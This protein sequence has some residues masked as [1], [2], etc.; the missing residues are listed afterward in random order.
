MVFYCS[1]HAFVS[2]YGS[3]RHLLKLTKIGISHFFFGNYRLVNRLVFLLTE[4]LGYTSKFLY[5]NLT[6]NLWILTNCLV[7]R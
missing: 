1:C 6:T 7:K 5:S 2:R 4:S 3:I